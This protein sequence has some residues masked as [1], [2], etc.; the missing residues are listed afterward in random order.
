M[1]L[2]RQTDRTGA[3]EPSARI[4]VVDDDA[5]TRAVLAE[6][7]SRR[8]YQVHEAADGLMVSTALQ[9]GDFPFDV[10]V[11]DWK[12]PG[13]DGLSVLEQLRTFAPESPAILISIA[14]DDQLRTEALSLGAFAVLRKPVRFEA[15]VALVER[16]LQHRGGD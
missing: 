8:G 14:A 10:V 9:A 12:M 6:V 1:M 5:G 15:L 2:R 13:L 3:T 16:A 4:L 11:L 7:L